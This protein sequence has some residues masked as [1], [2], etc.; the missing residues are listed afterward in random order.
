MRKLTK[1]EALYLESIVN[2]IHDQEIKNYILA[3]FDSQLDIVEQELDA[4]EAFSLA[5][6]SIS[7]W[8]TPSMKESFPWLS[9]KTKTISLRLNPFHVDALKKK[10]AETWIKYQTLITMLITQYV[11]G[12]ITMEV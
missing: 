1:K 4:E 5:S 11:S 7:R 12:K 8:Y 2:Q 10:S 9:Y 6:I 3:D